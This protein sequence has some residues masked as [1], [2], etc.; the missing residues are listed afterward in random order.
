MANRIQITTIICIALHIIN[1]SNAISE[2]AS[3]CKQYSRIIWR[4]SKQVNYPTL[5]C[6]FR[7]LESIPSN[8]LHNNLLLQLQL[9]NNNLSNITESP[10]KDLVALHILALHINNIAYL[11][12]SAFNGLTSLQVLNI[13]YNRLQVVPDDIFSNV[14]QL[15]LLDLSYNLLTQIPNK[16]IGSLLLLN[17][18]GMTGNYFISFELGKE[19]AT[20]RHL[21]LLYIANT[22]PTL[23]MNITNETFQYFLPEQQDSVAVWLLWYPVVSTN[24]L[25]KL[26]NV[27]EL[28]ITNLPN[29][30]FQST[31]CELKSL[32][33]LNLRAAL[34]AHSLYSLGKWNETLTSL[35][36]NF[37]IVPSIRG[38]AFIWVPFLQT[39]DLCRLELRFVSEDAFTGLGH[40]QQLSLANN[41]LRHVPS[42]A[43]KVFKKYMTLQHLDLSYNGIAGSISHD[44][45]AAVPFLTSLNMAGNMVNL[46]LDWTSVLVNL[47]YLNLENSYTTLFY[48]S[49]FP[50]LHT[51]LLGVPRQ[52]TWKRL[53]L[54][55]PVC[56]LASF[57]VHASLVN[58]KPYDKTVLAEVLGQ[59]CMY[60]KILDISG[61]FVKTNAFSK[62]QQAINLPNLGT[63]LAAYN[64]ITSVKLIQ[65]MHAPEL[66]ELDLR[67]NKLVSLEKDTLFPSGLQYLY[68][69]GNQLVSLNG[70]EKLAFLN[71]LL[72]ANNQI[73]S[74]PKYLLNKSPQSAL[75]TLDLGANPFDCTCDILPFKQWM[76]K[77]NITWLVPN[78]L[79]TCAS[80]Q[81]ME[82]TDIVHVTLDCRSHLLLYLAVSIT[83]AVIIAV[84]VA[85]AIRYRWHIKYKLFLILNYRRIKQY[86]DV[87][88]VRM[89]DLADINYPIYDAYIAYADENTQDER[90]VFNDLS[91]NLEGPDAFHLCIR[92][93]D[94]IPGSQ[95]LESISESIQQSEKTVLIL[96]PR[97][98]ESEWCYFEMQ[99]ARV[100]LFQENHDAIIMVMLEAIPDKKLTLSL[101]Q[102]L[103]EKDYFKWPHDKTGQNLFW[104][105]LKAELQRPAF[106]D[107]R[108]D[109]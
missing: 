22:Q 105:R 61:T 2:D 69:E 84:L 15:Q 83:C 42:H 19:F 44:A 82:G 34:N 35:T 74:V 101:R 14:T 7:N 80:P 98:V 56:V 8:N 109:A 11:T 88:A 64:D 23:K 66:R 25:G 63:L 99:T 79:Y 94:F 45:F 28:Q 27:T 47:T 106:V 20:L 24:S 67:Y 73:T 65:F 53:D 102:L 39:L 33:L 71:T 96:S 36:L 46:V 37:G 31:E 32:N 48:A 10:F 59:N 29:D 104:R 5:D 93:R 57:I 60:L 16:A 90:W 103:C 54:P 9:D 38:T 72:A 85:L 87:R 49:R 91:P 41:V 18:I 3:V 68:L 13:S 75:R 108:Y 100:R 51:L 12:H 62:K 78:D 17:K 81:N 26:T 50:S 40:L 77:D 97:F 107:R 55:K 6:S 52:E 58:F 4:A 92:R 95:I 21:S 70:L 30:H 89:N 43:F 76:M 86:A 1:S